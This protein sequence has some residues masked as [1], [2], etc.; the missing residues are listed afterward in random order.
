MGSAAFH[1]GQW[2]GQPPKLKEAT[3][4]FYFLFGFSYL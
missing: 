4:A 2:Q 1:F 3:G